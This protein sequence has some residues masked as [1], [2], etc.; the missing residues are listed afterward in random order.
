[1][2]GYILTIVLII[3]SLFY[4]VRST[5]RK[6]T[7]AMCDNERIFGKWN[8]VS[9]EAPRPVPYPDWSVEKTRPLPY[10]PFKYGPDYFIT[11]GIGRLDSNDWIE[12]DNQWTRYHQEKLSRLSGERASHL[13]KTA[14]EAKDAA[15]ETMELLCEYLVYRYPSLFEYR[16][17]DQNN[18]KQIRIKTTGEIYP[19]NCE[20]PL[21][22][23]SLLI[24]DDLAIMIEGSDGQ[25]YLKAGVILL[26]GF[27]RLEDKFN[28][29]LAQ[30]HLSVD[31]PRFKEKCN[32]VWNVSFK[33]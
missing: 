6:S 12:L 26:P 19:I 24:E 7:K 3:F 22:Y 33:K 14:P 8:P 1:M 5:R 27:W 21:K 20:D 30:I 13:C 32:I 23:A 9:F 16:F 11:M 31:V 18:E 10:R 2:L 29:S 25:Y 15:L 28:L 4:I 17:N